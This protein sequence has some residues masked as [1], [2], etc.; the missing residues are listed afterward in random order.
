MDQRIHI[1]AWAFAYSTIVTDVCAENIGRFGLPN[2]YSEADR[3][4]RHNPDRGP[5]RE[6]LAMFVNDTLWD[7][8]DRWRTGSYQRSIFWNYG[9]NE[10]RYH[11]EY[12]SPQTL[13]HPNKNGDRPYI[14]IANIYLGKNHF[15]DDMVLSYGVS[16]D[17]YNMTNMG[18][19]MHYLIHGAT[20]FGGVE[21]DGYMLEGGVQPNA[22][23]SLRKETLTNYGYFIPY[24][25]AKL[26]VRDQVFA[27]VDFIWSDMPQKFYTR[28]M[29]S[30]HLIGRS[31]RIPAPGKHRTDYIFGADIGYVWDDDYIE[32]DPSTVSSTE[33][34][35]RLRAGLRFH[36]HDFTLF[37]G[38]TYLSPEFDQ[39]SEGQFV[40]AISFQIN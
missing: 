17:I 29:T 33:F 30:G 34:R 21:L 12:I 32:G 23:A 11:S 38:P 6:S 2:S 15:F 18:V 4:I 25:E 9:Q 14:S 36:T 40:Q 10:F 31:Y 19:G 37:I 20:D 26:G 3:V 27:G 35:Y 13:Y 24:T 7:G 1:F 39:Q 28:D 5:S 22:S 16:A 8:K